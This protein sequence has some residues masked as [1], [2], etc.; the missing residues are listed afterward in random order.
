MI[1]QLE[2]SGGSILAF[3]ITGKVTLDEEQQWI[4]IFEKSLEKHDKVSTLII[5]G[6]EASWGVKAGIEDIKWLMTHLNK[7]HRFALVTDSSVWK[8][9]IKMDSPFASM[10]GIGEKYF[11][12]SELDNAWT[13][14]KK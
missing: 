11:P 7:L 13:W 12:L 5:L 6:E 8:W 2:K 14:V 10:M 4:Q 1:E 9:L 3:K